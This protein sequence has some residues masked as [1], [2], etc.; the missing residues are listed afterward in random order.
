VN[1]ALLA[2]AATGVQVGS[3]L[4][5]SE[6]IVAQVGAGRL[7]FLRYA[8]ALVFLLP[9]VWRSKAPQFAPRD[10]LPVALI[11]LG[12]F[13]L[14]IAL[15]NLAVLHASSARVSLVFATLPLMTIAVGWVAFRT[16][17]SGKNIAAISLTVVGVAVLLGGEA[18]GGGIALSEWVGLGC[19]VLAT[20]T[21]AV[22]SAF[23]GPYLR[24]YG[25]VK[26][27]AIA[28]GASLVP[29]GILAM[30]EG[31]GTA[32]STWGAQVFLLIGFV[33]LS[34]GIGYLMWLYALTHAPAGVVTAFL[35]LSPITAVALSMLVLDTPASAPLFA[36]LGLII[37]G[38]A[39]MALTSSRE[40][41]HVRRHR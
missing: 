36:A 5:A 39:A 29:L 21:G 32:V 41:S 14:L 40:K 15:L 8:I 28:M 16:G 31:G 1:R 23:Y 27:S 6:A 18:I 9:F 17:I 35:A 30:F 13:G 19:A 20:L 24:R 3:A 33:G 7:G 37:A 12:Q 11:G 38:L 25:V 10:L 34:S 26:V 22:C 4:V 2:A